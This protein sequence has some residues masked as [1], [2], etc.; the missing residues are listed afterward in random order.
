MN[1]ILAVPGLRQPCTTDL[2]ED[3]PQHTQLSVA[4]SAMRPALL[5]PQGALM[6]FRA[7]LAKC[8]LHVLC[9]TFAFWAGFLCYQGQAIWQD[10]DLPCIAGGQA[11]HLDIPRLI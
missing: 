1:D 5:Q 11:E 10:S 3:T 2:S 7:S 8:L 6:A 4:L 9:F